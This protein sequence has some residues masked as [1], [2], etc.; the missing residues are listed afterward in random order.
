MRVM[1]RMLAATYAESVSCTPMWAIGDPSGPI[2]NGTT[3][4]VRPF[5]APV[6]S[7]VISARI[8]SGSRQL[9]FGPASSAV[10][11]A[12]E[13]AVLDA[14]DVSRIGVRPV[15][16]RPLGLVE[17]GERA[18]V[19]ELLAQPV[20]LLGRSVAPRDA[21]GLQDRCPLVDPTL[22][23]FV[24]RGCAHVVLHSSLR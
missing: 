14:G 18:G 16:V 8:S 22:E 11:G 10:G 15:A 6:Y 4:I 13:R 17:R 5:I 23:A 7:F 1:I 21:V 20:V 24:A 2:E 12:D 19:D 3:Y 9:L